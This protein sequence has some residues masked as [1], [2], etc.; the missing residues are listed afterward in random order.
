[1]LLAKI[2]VVIGKKSLICVIFFRSDQSKVIHNDQLKNYI[3]T[4]FVYHLF[5]LL[6]HFLKDKKFNDDKN[7]KNAI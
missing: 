2:Y 5:Q 7:I 3:T 4:N 1:M 6:E